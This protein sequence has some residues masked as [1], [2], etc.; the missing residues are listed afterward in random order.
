V[1]EL[2]WNGSGPEFTLIWGGREWTL[3]VDGP[4]PGLCL[5]S[6]ETPSKLLSLDHLAG[7]SRRDFEAFTPQTLVD[8]ERYRSSVRATFAPPSWGGLRVRA[9]WSAAAAEAVDLEIQISASSVGELDELEVALVTRPGFPPIEQAGTPVQPVLPGPGPRGP[10]LW[11]APWGPTDLFYAEMVHPDDLARRKRAQP[12]S[13]QE[14]TSPAPEAHYSLF[15]LELEKG[16]I[17]RGRLRGSWFR[18][19]DPRAK[20]AALYADFLANA[21]PLGP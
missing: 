1:D 2:C 13:G 8:V 16:V 9:A 4:C 5:S 12:N 18:S 20:L 21:L 19:S 3:K 14:A 6:S 7:P 10:S 15:G 17:L 11:R